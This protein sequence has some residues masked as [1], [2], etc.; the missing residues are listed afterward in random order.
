MPN[1]LNFQIEDLLFIYRN[2]TNVGSAALNVC[3]ASATHHAEIAQA[4]RSTG[5]ARDVGSKDGLQV[6]MFEVG[7]FY[8]RCINTECLYLGSTSDCPCEGKPDWENEKPYDVLN[9]KE[10]TCAANSRVNYKQQTFA[11]YS[12]DPSEGT[13]ALS[14]FKPSRAEVD[15]NMTKMSLLAQCP[16][17]ASTNQAPSWKTL[18]E[19]VSTVVGA[20][21]VLVIV[22]VWRRRQ[23]RPAPWSNKG[24][25]ERLIGD[26]RDASFRDEREVSM[27]QQTGSG[28]PAPDRKSRRSSSSNNSRR[29][30]SSRGS[31][32]ETRSSRSGSRDANGNS[33][34]PILRE[35]ARRSVSILEDTWCN[36]RDSGDLGADGE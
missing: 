20:V 2:V 30:S 10:G 21:L 24:A 1:R 16:P 35:F 5:H 7:H 26:E 22:T 28:S 9:C 23:A 12:F 8:A 31:C 27:K 3:N 14:A 18:W 15:M 19:V 11:S 4:W 13:L 17:S 32:I 29:K 6:L 36:S 25:A 34:N 33:V